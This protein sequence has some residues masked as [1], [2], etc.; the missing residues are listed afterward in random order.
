MCGSVCYST[1]VCWEHGAHTE[2]PLC[3]AVSSVCLSEFRTMQR[4]AK[5]KQD[6]D[7][8]L[9]LCSLTIQRLHGVSCRL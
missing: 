1:Y 6:I 7:P 2:Q 8:L 9:Y 4:K 5:H 3:W